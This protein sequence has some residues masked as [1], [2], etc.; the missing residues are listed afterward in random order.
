LRE[1]KEGEGEKNI[2]MKKRLE[3]K[4]SSEEHVGQWKRAPNPSKKV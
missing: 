3:L 4:N 1:V 2:S